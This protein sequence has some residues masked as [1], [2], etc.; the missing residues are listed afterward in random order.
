MPAHSLRLTATSL[1][2]LLGATSLLIS[3]HLQA[4][5]ARLGHGFT[6]QHPRGQAMVKFAEELD[7]ASG[8]KIKVKIFANSTLGSEEKMLQS[9]QGGVLEFYMGSLVPFSVRKK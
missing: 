3:G 5:D 2:I 6:E 8:G 9:V 7:K 4:A 1:G